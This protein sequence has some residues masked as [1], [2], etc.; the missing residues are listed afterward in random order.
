MKITVEKLFYGFRVKNSWGHLNLS[1]SCLGNYCNQ[2]TG[3][4]APSTAS[5]S[6]QFVFIVRRM[7]IAL[8]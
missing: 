4:G 2:T 5:E 8:A 1:L 7:W 6:L 3:R